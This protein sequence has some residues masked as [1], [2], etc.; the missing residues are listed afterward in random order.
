MGRHGCMIRGGS[1]SYLSYI[2]FER[3]DDGYTTECRLWIIFFTWC[4]VKLDCCVT[5][6][7]DCHILIV[8]N[9]ISRMGIKMISWS[10]VVGDVTKTPDS[11]DHIQLNCL[12]FQG[13]NY[14]AIDHMG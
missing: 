9:Y 4:I 7:S 1:I 2:L 3:L 14:R 11:S 5:L 10:W 12:F 13:H 8:D 6:C